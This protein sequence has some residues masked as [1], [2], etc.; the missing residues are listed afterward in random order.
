MTPLPE[1]VRPAT[2]KEALAVIERLLAIIAEQEARIAGLQTQITALQAQVA[3][4]TERLGQTS[5]NSSRPPSADPP[6]VER[7]LKPPSGRRPGAQP[8]H[9]AQYRALVPVEEVAAVVP[10]KP[11]QCRGCGARL[12]GSDPAPR[13]HQVTELPP[14]RPTITEYQ[15]HTLTCQR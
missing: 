4:L 15:V 7:P 1:N 5:Q 2:L 8:G 12:G 10:V 6:T 11:R 14:V 13:R 9:A 3:A